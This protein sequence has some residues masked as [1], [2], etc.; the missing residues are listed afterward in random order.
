MGGVESHIYML[1]ERIQIV[2][3]HQASSVIGHECPPHAKT[4][5]LSTCFTG[6]SLLGFADA[7]SIHLNKFLEFTMADIDHSVCVSHTSKEN[8]VLRGCIDP[9]KVSVIP[10]AV[11]PTLFTPDPTRRKPG[12]L[13]IVIM[14]RLVYRK[15]GRPYSGGAAQGPETLSSRGCH[16]WR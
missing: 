16:H 7:S 5:G 13:T 1:R 2:H 12:A 6:H 11:D 9:K 15:E 14:S 8:T 10:S 3:S 4:M